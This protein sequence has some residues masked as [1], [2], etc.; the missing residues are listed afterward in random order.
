MRPMRRRFIVCSLD[1]QAGVGPCEWDSQEFCAVLK[2]NEYAALP[3]RLSCYALWIWK[4]RSAGT[5][6]TSKDCKCTENTSRTWRHS[7]IRCVSSRRK[8]DPLPVNFQSCFRARVVSFFLFV[9][10]LICSRCT[11][12]CSYTDSSCLLS[13]LCK[14]QSSFFM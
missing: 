13:V 9:F 8:C 5:Y 11:F 3:K 7:R 2:W 12:T 10:R 1:F 14:P 6:K 4:R